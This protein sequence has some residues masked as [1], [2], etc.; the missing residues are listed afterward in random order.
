MAHIWASRTGKIA[1]FTMAVA[2]TLLAGAWAATTVAR[3]ASAAGPFT[4][5]HGSYT[6]GTDAC[7]ACHRSHTG[8][9][10]NLLKSA[11]PQSTLCFS[12]HDGT[13][14]NYNVAAQYADI[15]VPANDAATSSFYS[16]PAT[17]TSTHVSG[18]TD[19]FAGV[20]NRHA[21][22]G[23]CHNPHSASSAAP[24]QTTSGWTASGSLANISGATATTPQTWKN[25]IA[26]EYELCL[27][28]HSGYT[29][30]LSYTKESYKKTDKRTELD[31]ANA[32]Y[33]P[34]EAPGKNTTTAMA[35]SLAGG[36]LWQF[37]TTGATSTVRCANCHGNYRLVGSPPTPNAP[38]SSARLAPHASQ[39]R[40]LLIANYRDRLL[41]TSTEAYA[42]NDF[43]LCYLCHKEA[44][45]QDTS[46]S[47]RTDTNFRFHG[48]H[49]G[50]IS[51]NPGGGGAGTDID[52]AGV[53]QGN[54]I[55]AECHYRVHGTALAPWSGNQ[56]YQRGVNFAPNVRPVGGQT[57][58][59]WSG[60]ANKTCTLVC[61]GKSHNPESY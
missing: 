50:N 43:A 38:A 59:N 37:T 41:K 49:L 11:E 33:H 61:H 3:P 17:T 60:P 2:M 5:P 25:P 44:P 28:C 15:N 20:L 18:Q 45:F 21:Q 42:T 30:L 55:C 31:P 40:G 8:Q 4:N 26:Y 29:Q 51:G 39:Y 57:N 13:G 36:K 35:N 10:K 19:E 32:S 6:A 16:H 53:G 22:C 1:A 24:S 52:T 47:T 48:F 9:N 46:G 58:P 23:D 7:A 27:K 14:A 34:V 12:C 56:N 54:G